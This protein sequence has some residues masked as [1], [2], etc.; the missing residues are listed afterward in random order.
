MKSFLRKS[1][2]SSST[3]SGFRGMEISQTILKGLNVNNI[4][5]SLVKERVP[6]K[7]N[8]EGV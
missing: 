1:D 6:P 8:T 2:L 4:R 7:Q 3:L 5:R